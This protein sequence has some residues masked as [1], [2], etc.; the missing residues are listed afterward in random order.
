MIDSEWSV[1]GLAR[2]TAGTIG[3]GTLTVNTGGAYVM[4][5]NGSTGTVNN[6]VLTLANNLVLKGGAVWAIDDYDHISGTLN[7]GPAGGFLG[8][9][10]LGGTGNYSS[11]AGHGF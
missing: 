8:S 10:Y 5:L 1:N 6:T 4:D 2:V 9:T 7:V 3:T 11:T